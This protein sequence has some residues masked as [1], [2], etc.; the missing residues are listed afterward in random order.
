MPNE[1][2][3]MPEK[4]VL[5]QNHGLELV[6]GEVSMDGDFL[7]S[8]EGLTEPRMGWWCNV[9]SRWTINDLDE[10]YDVGKLTPIAKVVKVQPVEGVGEFSKAS[11]DLHRRTVAGDWDHRI[12]DAVSIALDGQVGA[13][14]DVARL[15][16]QIEGGRSNDKLKTACEIAVAWIR[17]AQDL[18]EKIKRLESEANREYR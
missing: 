15:R 2:L 9:N 14:D 13:V 5:D 17:L 8:E 4:V 1:P 10:G 3:K 7:L 6:T 11:R 12:I 18:K 16:S